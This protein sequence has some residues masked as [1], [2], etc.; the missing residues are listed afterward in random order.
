MSFQDQLGKPYRELGSPRLLRRAMAI[1]LSVLMAAFALF[2]PA[3][4]ASASADTSG[5]ASVRATGKKTFSVV[6]QFSSG[7]ATPTKVTQKRIKAAVKSV[8]VLKAPKKDQ[9]LRIVAV[10]EGNCN[11]ARSFVQTRGEYGCAWR[12][13]ATKR[14]RSL[15]SVA[16]KAGFKGKIVKAVKRS[17][18]IRKSLKRKLSPAK[19]T[20]T[21]TVLGVPVPTPPNPPTPPTP[22]TPPVHTVPG[23]PGTPAG[24]PGDTQIALTWTAPTSNGGA[25]ITAYEVRSTINGGTSWTE[26]PTGCAGLANV[27]TCTATGLTNATPY[28]YEVRAVNSVGAGPWSGMSTSVSPSTAFAAW[29]DNVKGQLGNG[30]TTNSHVPVATGTAGAFAGKPVTQIAAGATHACAVVDSR[31][32]CWG[33]NF[34][35][36]LGNNTSVDSD[37]PV[38]VNTSGALS[39]KSVTQVAAGDTFSCAIADTKAYCWGANEPVKVPVPVDTSGVLAGKTLTQISAGDGQACAVSDDGGVYCWGTDWEPAAMAGVLTGKAATQV[40]VGASHACAVADQKAYCWG[41]NGSGQLGNGS[42][43]DSAT[44]VAVE[45]TGV[46]SGVVTQVAAGNGH[47]CA[48]SGG[49]AFCWGDNNAGQLGNGTNTQHSSPVA[50]SKSGALLGKTVTQIAAG[51]F[52]T[53]AV[54][55]GKAYCWGGNTDGQ[56]GDGTTTN[57]N[58][59]IEVNTSAVLPDKDVVQVASGEDFTFVLAP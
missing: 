59:P 21:F 19:S 18:P 26:N 20:M 56:L 23:T 4:T 31:A 34:N 49:D 30:N 36:Q 47:S 33:N 17:T 25:A 28:Q 51:D 12:T 8:N 35:G 1:S 29:G 5:P 10:A 42:T 53:C 2:V 40:D 57:S 58:V 9:T 45:T 13:L 38:A 24:V 43:V 48:L 32:Y 6:A 27:L 55:S 44:P 39:G 41:S 7:K 15:Q 14:A 11:T 46:L 3:T 22:P 16:R 37:L 54:A 52:N 50:V